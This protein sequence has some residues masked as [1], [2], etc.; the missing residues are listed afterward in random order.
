MAGTDLGYYRFIF[1]NDKFIN[2]SGLPQ[3]RDAPGPYVGKSDSRLDGGIQLV[4]T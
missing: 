3:K 1:A 4:I 2:V